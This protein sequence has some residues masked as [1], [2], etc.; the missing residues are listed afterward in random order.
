MSLKL[1]ALIILVVGGVLFVSFLLYE[2]RKRDKEQGGELAVNHIKRDNP[3]SSPANRGN[4]VHD[5][6][7]D[8]D[9]EPGMVNDPYS[10]YVARKYLINRQQTELYDRLENLLSGD[11]R[12]S[13]RIRMTDVIRPEKEIME[14][15]SERSRIM[16]S[17]FQNA[18]FDFVVTDLENGE[19]RGVVMSENSLTFLNDSAF[20]IEILNRLNIPLYRYDESYTYSDDQLSNLLYETFDGASHDDK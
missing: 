4:S 13:P 19:I 12:I 10:G 5:L 3:V 8:E 2:K 6:F 9:D 15:E 17:R 7:I 11:F 16:N 1:L 18:R 20:V 14:Y